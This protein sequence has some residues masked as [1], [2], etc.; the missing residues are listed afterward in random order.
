MLKIFFVS[1]RIRTPDSSCF[2]CLEN[3][4]NELMEKVKSSN[5][6]S[7]CGFGEA[8]NNSGRMTCSSCK[9]F[10]SKSIY[11]FSKLIREFL[12]RFIF[13]NNRIKINVDVVDWK[14]EDLCND[15]NIETCRIKYC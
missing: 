10:S 13:L 11:W 7:V 1:G 4:L 15:N 2:N 14:I 3:L 12:F 8:K 6:C 5:N 9:V